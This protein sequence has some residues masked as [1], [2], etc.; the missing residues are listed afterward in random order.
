MVYLISAGQGAL[1]SFVYGSTIALSGCIHAAIGG[2]AA[3]FSKDASVA[4]GIAIGFAGLEVFFLIVTNSLRAF[5][6]LSWLSPMAWHRL[7]EPYL[8]NRALPLLIMT[9]L[10]FCLSWVAFWLSEKRDLGE[11]ILQEKTGKGEAAK[12]F[13]SPFAL[14]WR[15]RKGTLLGLCAG[16]LL[17]GGAIGGMGQTISEAAG[18]D[19]LLGGLGGMDW[20]S[21]VGNQYAFLAIFVYILSLA[22][23]L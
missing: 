15:L 17:I 5:H 10:T 14:A 13:S 6:S 1:G 18:I 12:G 22:L 7:T 19:D 3:Q 9:L 16:M 20:I 8:S 11:G 23:G 21:R 4:R 2:I